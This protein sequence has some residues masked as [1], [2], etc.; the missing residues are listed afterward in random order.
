[1]YRLSVIISEIYNK[2]LPLA[3]K[4]GIQLNLDMVDTSIVIE[5]LAGIKSDVE[6][7]VGEAIG[8]SA[9]GEIAIQVNSHEITITDTGTTLSRP[10]CALLSNKYV[11]V[12]SRVGFGTKVRISLGRQAEQIEAGEKDTVGVADES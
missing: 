4:N 8:R 5:E 7:A 12:S 3:E 9:E 2:F 11:D 1:M 10:V 6:K